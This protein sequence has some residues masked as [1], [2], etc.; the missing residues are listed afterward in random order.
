MTKPP[1]LVEIERRKKIAG[2]LR[3]CLRPY[4][5]QEE[6]DETELQVHKLFVVESTGNQ[7]GVSRAILDTMFPRATAPCDLYHYTSLSKLKSMASSG[8]LRLYAVRKRLGQGELDTFAKAHGLRG[9][10]DSSQG[11]PFLEELS[12]DLF[13]ASMT[14]VP[15]KD[16]SLMWGYFAEGTGARLQFRIAPKAA[17]LRSIQYERGATKTVLQEINE[18]LAREGQPRFVPWMLSRIVALGNCLDAPLLRGNLETYYKENLE[19]YY[20][21]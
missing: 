3:E 6:I 19:T 14:R 10:L 13:Y 8:E 7:R 2:I 15:P 12:D 1:I 4:G 18:A 20:K 17:E 21:E 11:P 16:P 5:L 9:Y